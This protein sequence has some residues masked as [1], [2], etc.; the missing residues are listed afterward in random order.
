MTAPGPWPALLGAVTGLVWLALALR[1]ARD[2]RLAPRLPPA[3]VEAPPTTVLLPVRDEEEN[4]AACAA[5]L[6]AQ[7]GSPALRVIDDGSSDRTPA[8]LAGLAASEP[9]LSAL[10]ARPL[11]AGWEGA[12]GD[13]LLR[14]PARHV[15]DHAL[16]VGVCEFHAAAPLP[17]R[18]LQL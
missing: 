9:R 6:L 14:D 18:C 8:I 15:L 16:L 12:V 11:A 17:G 5:T 3:R 10:R 2:R 4:L 1:L 7:H 13:L